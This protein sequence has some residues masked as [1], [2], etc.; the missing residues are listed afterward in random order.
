MLIAVNAAAFAALA[1][2][3]LLPFTAKA[4][5]FVEYAYVKTSH[6]ALAQA[7]WLK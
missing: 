7:S 3:S 5:N 4:I 1:S 6:N 2:S